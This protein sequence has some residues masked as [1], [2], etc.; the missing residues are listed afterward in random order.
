[1]ISN[2]RSGKDIFDNK[3]V[4]NEQK[5]EVFS[6]QQLHYQKFIQSMNFYKEKIDF[7]KVHNELGKVTKL[8]K[9]IIEN[10]FITRK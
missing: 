8:I 9:I 2:A 4:T 3:P 6:N 10:S 1:M 7:L 5:Q